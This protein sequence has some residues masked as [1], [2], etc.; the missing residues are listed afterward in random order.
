MPKRESWAEDGS[1]ERPWLDL[2]LL[3]EE[4]VR[5]VRHSLSEQ[6]AG[7]IK[8]HIL[9]LDLPPG[10]R[11]VV[12]ALAEQLG[13]SRTP[14]REALR[15][16]VAQGLV[17]Y[18]GNTYV[19]T[20]YTRPDVEDLFAIRRALEALAVRQASQRMSSGTVGELRALCERGQGSIAVGDTE[21][22]ISMDLQFHTIISQASQNARLQGLLDGLRE[23][24]W[25]IRR[26]GFL[27]TLVEPVEQMTLEEHIAILER[28]SAGD[29]EGAS[30]LM[31]EH[32]YKGEQRTLEWLGL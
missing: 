10:T 18:D 1:Q 26:W 21:F 22:L 2:L 7:V 9:S 23:Q 19:V 28:L 15:A 11:L 30:R 29:G 24:C 5:I 12:D 25:L 16:L 3:R 14:V 8:S 17:T 6:A 4:P 27:R 20:T 31:E 13:V 32:L